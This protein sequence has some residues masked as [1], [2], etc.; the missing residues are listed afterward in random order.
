MVEPVVVK[1][2]PMEGLGLFPAGRFAPLPRD[3]SG[4]T[5]GVFAEGNFRCWRGRK[6]YVY[7]CG[8]GRGTHGGG[9]P[10]SDIRDV[11]LIQKVGPVGAT[12]EAQGFCVCLASPASAEETFP[13]RGL[14]LRFACSLDVLG[15]SVHTIA[16]NCKG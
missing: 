10:F 3:D 8:C 16:G 13:A 7:G 6:G 12:G 2:E 15:S 4:W 9:L 14:V 5:S 1:F 11:V